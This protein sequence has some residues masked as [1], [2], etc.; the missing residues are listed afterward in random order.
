MAILF[1]FAA[2]LV[3]IALY[4]LNEFILRRGAKRLPLPPGP[5][6]LPLVGNIKDL[7]PPGSTECLHWLQYK[8][9][10]GP[11]NSFTVLGQTIITI[12]DRDVA[13]ELMD[14]R[15]TVHSG[16]HDMKFVNMCGWGD[17]MGA[18][19]LNDSFKA[20]RKHISQQ[21]GSKASVSRFWPLQEII[22]GRFLWRANKDHGQDLEQHIKT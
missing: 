6:G 9:V 13:S 1:V 7:P 17:L 21:I 22:V 3:A 8:D 11:I 12:H 16:R 20:Q 18:Q 10:Y 4:F 15:S 14:K 2:S 19:S 5:K